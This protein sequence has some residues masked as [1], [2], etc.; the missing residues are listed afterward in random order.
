MKKVL[1]AA[2]ALASVVA[3]SQQVVTGEVLDSD[4]KAVANAEVKVEN[5]NVT[6]M[7]DENGKFSIE[8]PTDKAFL[9]ISAKDFHTFR[10]SVS[11]D[12]PMVFVTLKEGAKEISELVLSAQKKLEVNK[13][14]IKNIDAPMTVSVLNNATLQK[15][16]ITTFDEAANMVAGLHA[17]R[18]YGGFQGFNIRGFNDLVVLYDGMRDERHSYFNVAPMSNLANVERVEMLKGPSSDM[19]GH[20]ALGGIIN[21]VRKK[22]TYT[23]HGDAKFTIGSYN[24]YNGIV[25]IGGP[26][27]S[28]LR[29]RVDAATLNSK[30]FRGVKENYINASV[31]LHYTPNE[32]NKFE[33]YYQFADNEFGGD[34]GIPA[35]DNGTVLYDWISPKSNFANPLDRLKQKSHE[36]YIKYTHRFLD[37]SQIDYKVTYSDDNYDYLMAE[38]LNVDPINKQVS[39]DNGSEYHFNR[40]NRALVSQLDYSFK[41]NTFGIK[42]K[43]VVGNVT[44]YLDKPNYFG[45]TPSYIINGRK[46]VNIGKTQI[47]DEFSSAVYVQDWIE[48]SDRVKLLGGARYTYLSGDY[49]ARKKIGQP[50]EFQ[51][52][53]VRNFTYRG[54]ISVQP[55]KDFMTVYASASSFFKPT[56]EHNHKKGQIF[57]PGSGLQVEGGI[58]LEKKNKFNFSAVAFYIERKNFVVGHNTLEV[59]DKAI[60]K[61]FEIDADAELTQGLYLKV[62]YAF[63]DAFYAGQ[64]RLVDYRYSS[65]KDISYNRAY[66]VPKH[67]VSAWVNYEP[68]FVEGLG[69]GVG[70]FYTDK[71]YQ[72]QHNDQYLPSYTILNGTVYYQ[73]KNRLRF[74]VNVDNILNKTYYKS[75]L[76]ANDTGGMMQMYPGKD[77]NYRFSVSY[78]F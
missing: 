17:Y 26:I 42:H 5:S 55:V 30:G 4:G 48:L 53:I 27:S 41:F 8:V 13:L 51:K 40:I 25:G 33:F 67:S 12:T 70:G 9:T 50:F 56:R 43:V 1:S 57:D 78:S 16:N 49:G 71:V 60:S 7:T 22:P 24:T 64:D 11:K 52:S 29:Y 45:N 3:F 66:N 14:N 59:L 15:W 38:I 73:M 36:T 74:G 23:T 76:S 65:L 31:M 72:E 75:S 6:V 58:K 62:G 28:K 46:K 10:R 61:G 44:S 19:F 47:M 2:L 20:S 69:I 68:T 54:A 35:N 34:T 32:R 37:K 18:Q 63:T 39:I 21:V 77:R